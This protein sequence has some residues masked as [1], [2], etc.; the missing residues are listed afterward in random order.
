MRHRVAPVEYYH[1]PRAATSRIENAVR[2]IPEG[3]RHN[4]NRNTTPAQNVI[5]IHAS[6]R[7]IGCRM[8]HYTPRQQKNGDGEGTRQL[9]H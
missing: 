1:T 3:H 4:N 7:V 5:G 8:R 2:V 6:L 9:R